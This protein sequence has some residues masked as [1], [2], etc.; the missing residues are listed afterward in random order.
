[1]NT[2]IFFTLICL[3][4]VGCTAA[5]AQP[6]QDASPPVTVPETDYANM[7]NPASAYCEKRDT[8]WKSE[9]PKM[10][11]KPVF[12]LRQMV[13]NVKNGPTS[14]VSVPW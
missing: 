6:G 3:F 13:V 5:V 14:A 10:A 1:M 9:L 2:K 11:A 8:N 7:P 4:L 12:V